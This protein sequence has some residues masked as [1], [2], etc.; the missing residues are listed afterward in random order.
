MNKTFA[1]VMLSFVGSVA[2][3]AATD[4]CSNSTDSLSGSVTIT[5]AT[6]QQLLSLSGTCSMEGYTFSN[7][8]VYSQSGFATG[9]T[10]SLTVTIDSGG[11]EGLLAIAYGVNP[12]DPIDV[13]V[14]YEI[15]PG[16]T[17][18]ELENGSASSVTEN[19]CSALGGTYGENTTCASAADTLAPQLNTYSSGPTTDSVSVMAALEDI[20]TKDV[21]GGSEIYQFVAPEP[22]TFSLMGIGLLGIGLVGRRFRK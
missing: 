19:I 11:T 3:F 5:S 7:F 14:T 1:I 8:D 17:Q 13:V 15:T 22:M 12:G 2:G 21:S 10:L 6:G 18:M 20:V 16:V 4:G 9:N